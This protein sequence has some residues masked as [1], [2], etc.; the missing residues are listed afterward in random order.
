MMTF[1]KSQFEVKSLLFPFLIFCYVLIVFY[2]AFYTNSPLLQTDQP[3]WASVAYLMRAE[4][5]PDQGWFWNVVFDQGGAGQ[6]MGKIYSIPLILPWLFTY[7]FSAATAVKLATVSSSILFL[8]SFYY[9]AKLYVSKGYAFLSA[10]VILTPMFDNLVSGMWY[11]YFSLGCG[12]SFWL[13]CHYFFKDQS[14]IAFILGVFSFASAFYA[15]PVGVILC[16]TVLLAYLILVARSEGSHKLVIFTSFLSIF[17]LAILLAFPQVQAIIGLD[18]GPYLTSSGQVTHNPLVTTGLTETFRRLLFLRIWGGVSESRTNLLFILIN[19]VA[20][21][22]L[23]LLGLYALKTGKDNKKTLPLCLLFVTN[24]ILISRVYNYLNIDI[25]VLR[26]LSFFYDRFQLLSQIYIVLIAGMGLQFFSTY[27]FKKTFFNLVY[28]FL[29][30]NLIFIAIRTPKKNYWDHT[31]QLGTFEESLLLAD[32]QDLWQWL[33]DNVNTNKER[34]YFEDTYG[35]FQW[36]DS[37]SPEAFKTHLLSLTS[38]NTNVRQIGGWCGFSTAFSRK[39]EQGTIF[40]KSIHDTDFNDQ[41]IHNRMKSMNC[42]YIVCY[43]DIVINYL[44]KTPFL[45]E[46][47]NFG[48]FYVF[49]YSEMVPTWAYHTATGKKV[50]YIRHSSSH[51]EVIA[52]G[53]KGDSIFISMAYNPHYLAIYKDHSVSISNADLFMSI[54]LPDNGRQSIDF[55]YVFRKKIAIF[56]V[57]LGLF[58]TVFLGVGIYRILP[59]RRDFPKSS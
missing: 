9:V 1:S 32:V 19:M 46:T 6:T 10:L 39:Y 7:F 2:P 35:K 49:K 13:C 33:T 5:F 28:Y 55:Y 31:N 50:D 14:W 48:V 36:N 59:A 38:M 37:S 47:S 58:L 34:V 3:L 12:L 42:R 8:L 41:F 18:A 20:V 21:W 25:G 43:S 17:C 53:E 16:T 45:E 11:N 40:G 22:G 44:K 57:G 51:F 15:H 26:S 27:R 56:L 30:I 54:E 23:V 52:D 4:I 24:V 29:I